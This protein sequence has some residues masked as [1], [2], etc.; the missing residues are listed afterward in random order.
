MIIIMPQNL[1]LYSM[2]FR[3]LSKSIHMVEYSLDVLYIYVINL[4][5]KTTPLGGIP[6]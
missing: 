6:V 1:V 2:E 4:V 3:L 5:K